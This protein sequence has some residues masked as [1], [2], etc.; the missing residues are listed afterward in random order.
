MKRGAQMSAAGTLS[1]LGSRI[2][3]A[4]PRADSRAPVSDSARELIRI[5]SWQGPIVEGDL[6]KNA[7]KV[8]E[9]IDETRP[10][11]LDFLCF[12]ECYLSGYQPE[13]VKKCAVPAT[14]PAIA[15]LVGLTRNDDTV[16][17]VGF[18]ELK[19]GKVFNTVLVAYKGRV[20]GLP[21]K[22]MLVPKYDPATLILIWKCR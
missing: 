4:A 7:A 12:P 13:S 8:K 22:T 15:D 1:A 2:T 10:L 21:H 16:V 18:S 19:G 6:A 14:D 9:V 17:L 11:Q 20:L 3:E 5:G